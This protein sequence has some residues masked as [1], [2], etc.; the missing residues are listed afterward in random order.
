MVLRVC[1]VQIAGC[2]SDEAYYTAHPQSMDPSTVVP[3]YQGPALPCTST[4]ISA[5]RR[6]SSSRA[7]FCSTP[8]EIGHDRGTVA[9]AGSSSFQCRRPLFTVRVYLAV[10]LFVCSS[11]LS[12]AWGMDVMCFFYLGL[13][14]PEF[15]KKNLNDLVWVPEAG[16]ASGG[17][18]RASV[19]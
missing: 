12:Y 1:T 19:G 17:R 11:A 3:L 15:K 5:V 7:H 8:R 10:S 13:A 4:S 2:V 9:K 16:G 14:A 18:G 6:G